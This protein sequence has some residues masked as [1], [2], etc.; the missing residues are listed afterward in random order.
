MNPP[1]PMFHRLMVLFS[2][3]VAVPLTV[4][5]ALLGFSS[6]SALVKSAAEVREVA[7]S[8]LQTASLLMA[9]LARKKT[10]ESANSVIDIGLRELKHLRNEQEQLSDRVVARVTKGIISAGGRALETAADRM[11]T[12]NSRV[13]RESSTKAQEAHRAALKDVSGQ[14]TEVFT[15]TFKQ[16]GR[17]LAEA[18]R[19]LVLRLASDLNL[20]RARGM[21]DRVD[22]VVEEAKTTLYAIAV[23]PE[24]TAARPGELPEVLTAQLDQ[25]LSLLWGVV[26][27]DAGGTVLARVPRF[28]TVPTPLLDEVRQCTAQG[29]AYVGPVTFA[30]GGRR[31]PILRVAVPMAATA[32]QPA[33][34]LLGL[35]R[36]SGYPLPVG[37]TAQQSALESTAPPGTRLSF[38]ADAAGR[39]IAYQ[40]P[41]LGRTPLTLGEPLRGELANLVASLPQTPRYDIANLEL[42]PGTMLLCAYARPHSEQVPWIAVA[43]VPREEAMAAARETVRQM[44]TA[45]DEAARKTAERSAALASTALDTAVAAQERVARSAMQETR[46]DS[47]SL[48]QTAKANWR[49]HQSEAAKQARTGFREKSEK[50]AKT[51]LVNLREDAQDAA[52][53]AIEDFDRR[54]DMLQRMAYLRATTQAAT[55]AYDA[56]EKAMIRSTQ[57]IC[58]FLVLA[59]VLAAV[60]A[61]SIVRPIGELASGAQALA[62]GD[63]AQRVPVRSGDELGRLA[64]SFNDMAAALQTHQTQL[65]Q[66]NAALAE[67]R[68]RIRTIVATSPDGLVMLDEHDQISLV[69]PAARLCLQ[70]VG[71][72]VDLHTMSPELLPKSVLSAVGACLEAATDAQPS[73]VDVVLEGP[74]K[75]VIQASSLGMSGRNGTLGGRLLHLRDV[76]RERE[77]DE[78]KSSFISLVSHEMRTPMTSIIGFSSYLLAGKLGVLADPQKTAAESIHRQ[79]RRLS[80]IISD[81]LDVSRIESGHLELRAEPLSMPDLAAQVLDDLQPQADEHGVQLSVEA[82][83]AAAELF[84]LGD[85]A[86]VSQVL[87]NLVGN[88]VKFTQAA[89]RITV[90]IARERDMILTEVEDTGA[91][92]PPDELPR[93]FDRFYQVERVVER[94]TSGTGLGLA[95]VKNIVEAHGGEVAVRSEVGQ[96]TT[97]RFTLP[98]GSMADS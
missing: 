43:V 44:E 38:V 60:T 91:G 46:A 85:V 71:E 28:A 39:V 87:T 73:R 93:I 13:L 97:F 33:R 49:R 15:D 48:M 40:G 20:E 77:I 32:E 37:G 5:G 95:I 84:A 89:G 94:K 14:L 54:A 8:S 79:A 56:A 16:S 90:R 10:Q 17:E 41:Q 36:V 9:D 45:S 11:L 92:I 50:A 57:L 3:L 82:T 2:L 25:Y 61:R 55:S 64:T 23:S 22:A 4:S 81:F 24:V 86:R 31:F 98:A 69:N 75:R 65:A 80:A 88:S 63:L 34:A 66:S 78:M 52:E 51:V 70:P 58:V 68:D 6:K 18:N 7:V 19:G 30:G 72:K 96:G 47:E 76:T 67:E 29:N 35:V 53:N 1:R 62:A 83:G 74:P 27:V 12:A 21:A 26:V 59:A 42:R